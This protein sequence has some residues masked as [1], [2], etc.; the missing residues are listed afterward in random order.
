MEGGAPFRADFCWV[1]TDGAVILG[2]LDGTDKYV[3]EEM[4]RGRSLDEVL[5]DEKTR[6]SRISLYDVS[7]MRFRF[8]LTGDPR[9]FSAL[10]DEYGVPKRGSTLAFP[11]DV[12]VLP[13]W[14]SLRRSA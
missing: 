12:H 5:S 3:V 8:G 11:D 4:T 2:E 14:G 13:D 7:V 9:S 1:R 10:L 6:T